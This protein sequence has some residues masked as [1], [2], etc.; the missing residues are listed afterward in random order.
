MKTAAD[1]AIF[2]NQ[3]LIGNKEKSLW[4]ACA[5]KK[6]E[7]YCW[8]F[9]KVS[10]GKFL[11]VSLFVFINHQGTTSTRDKLKKVHLNSRGYEDS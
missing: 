11:S 3:L 5:K 8:F 1:E 2:K 10:Q 6:V 7:E 4:I 9:E